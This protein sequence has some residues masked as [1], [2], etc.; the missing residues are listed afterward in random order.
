MRA[1]YSEVFQKADAVEKYDT[2]VYAPGTYAS[3]ISRRQRAYLR[4]LVDRE[5]RQRRPVQHD[6]GCGTGRAVRLLRGLVR[7]A[8]GYDSSAAMLDQARGANLPAQWHQVPDTGPQPRPAASSGPAIVTVFRVLLNAPQPTRER[9]MAFAARALPLSDSGLLVVENHGNA[10]SLR[11]LARRRHA[12]DPWFNELRHRD[13]LHLL[14]R[15]GFELVRRQ[16]FAVFPPGAYRRAW[17]RPVVRRLDD[18]LCRTG[19]VS[20]FCTDVL[21]VARRRPAAKCSWRNRS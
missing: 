11:H 15:Y 6:F 10:S 7:E 13:V 17:L 12:G 19:L 2:V 21:Y 18:I 1:D 5:Y 20:G 4:R 16:G 14:N 9:V 3:A 8:H